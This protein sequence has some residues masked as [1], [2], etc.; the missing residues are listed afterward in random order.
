MTMTIIINKQVFPTK[1]E[2]SNIITLE[3]TN[4]N[5]R[6]FMVFSIEDIKEIVNVYNEYKGDNQH[7]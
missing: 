5:G 6:N 2:I 1:C 7:G 3:Q 4:N